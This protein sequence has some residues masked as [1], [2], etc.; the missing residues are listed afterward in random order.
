MVTVCLHQ[1]GNLVLYWNCQAVEDTYDQKWPDLRP[2]EIKREHRFIDIN[3]DQI[4]IERNTPLLRKGK[5]ESVTIGLTSEQ[6]IS[7]DDTQVVA[8]LRDKSGESPM[9]N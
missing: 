1:S 8:S 7:T 9:Q 2:G 6:R 5:Y 4:L 3:F